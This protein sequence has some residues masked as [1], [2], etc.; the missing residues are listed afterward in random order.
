MIETVEDG[1]EEKRGRALR[2]ETLSGRYERAE[3]SQSA[4]A[5]TGNP[6]VRKQWSRKVPKVIVQYSP[7]YVQKK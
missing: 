2:N 7:F 5:G 6:H 3:Q 4:A 1:Q